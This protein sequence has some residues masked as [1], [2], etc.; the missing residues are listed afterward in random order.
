MHIIAIGCSHTWGEGLKDV[1]PK[2]NFRLKPSDFAWPSLLAN[3]L[4]CEVDNQAVRGAG[5]LEILWRLLRMQPPTDSLILI[6]WSHFSRYDFWRF[7]SFEKGTRENGILNP[8][9]QTL[10][11]SNQDWFADNGIR[12]WLAIHHCSLWLKDRGNKFF[13]IVLTND[14]DINPIPG[15]LNIP[16]LIDVHTLATK[17]PLDT[18]LDNKHPGPVTQQFICDTVF[19]YIKSNNELR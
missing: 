12:N 18:A 3:K 7:Q 2:D 17:F 14:K 1:H 10:N 11:E 19:D 5:N 15:K 9:L 16:N 4:N 8:I 13:N 6:Q